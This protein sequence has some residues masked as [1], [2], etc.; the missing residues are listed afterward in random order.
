M[1]SDNI[2][3]AWVLGPKAVAAFYLTQQLASLGQSQLKGFGS[4]TWAGLT[5]LHTRGDAATFQTRLLELT[6]MVSGL[7]LALL[8]PIAAFNHSF[9]RLWVGDDSFAGDAV[10]LLACFNALL[11]AVYALWGWT[12]LGTGHIRRWMPYA[13]LSTSVNV[14]A[15]VLGTLK[16]GVVGPLLGTTT[17]FLLVTS[18]AL[19]LTLHQVFGIPSWTLWRTALAPLLW[20]LPYAVALWCISLY[21]PPADWP[22]FLAASGLGTATGLALWWRL[23]LGHAQRREWRARLRGIL[24]R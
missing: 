19:P 10:T 22:G 13:V 7:G 11:W 9:V 4:A 14:G 6:G 21:W 20:G 2:L 1:V 5:D 12:L 24:P 15:S 17:G 16:M 18:W 3:I 23:S 8:A